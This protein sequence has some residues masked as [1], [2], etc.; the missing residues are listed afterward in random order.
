VTMV[1]AKVGKT[2]VY[3]A[4][5]CALRKNR[6][7]DF[8][9]AFVAPSFNREPTATA[10]FVLHSGSKAQSSRDGDSNPAVA[11]GSRLNDAT[12]ARRELLPGRG[13]E[14]YNSSDGRTRPQ[15]R[16]SDEEG[17]DPALHRL[18]RYT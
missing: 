14:T 17:N 11:V 1:N 12:A 13:R 10:R 9:W 5:S 2:I 6:P 4:L 15:R 18:R 3:P 7:D 8:R 16:V